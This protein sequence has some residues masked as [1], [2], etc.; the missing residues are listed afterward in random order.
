MFHVVITVTDLGI[1]K[2]IVLNSPGDHRVRNYTIK[3]IGSNSYVSEAPY[4]FLVMNSAIIS[5]ARGLVPTVVH[6]YV[7]SPIDAIE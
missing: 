7:D 4:S 2:S 6:L 1:V 5:V 3:S